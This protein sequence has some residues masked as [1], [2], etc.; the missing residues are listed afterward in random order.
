VTVV[1]GYVPT[2]TGYSAVKEAEREAR[3]RGVAVVV[4]NV[5]GAAGYTV[6][7]AADERNL[8]AVTAR[9]TESG[10]PNSLRQVTD[11]AAPADVI[12]GVAREV[13]ASLI[14]LGLHQRSWIAKRVLGSTARSV[15]LAAPC[16]VLI[17]PD[18]DQHET[19]PPLRD[20][21]PP[22]RFMG[23]TSDGGSDS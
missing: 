11:D 13:D 14:V 18:I 22:L 15:V 8:D 20:E 21:A 5:V 9:L 17:V 12:L 6:P 16:P 7:T 19:E 4:V 1:I 3:S 2:E 23:Q 10:V